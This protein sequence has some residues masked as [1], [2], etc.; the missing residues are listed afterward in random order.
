MSC[1]IIHLSISFPKPSDASFLIG[2]CF[3]S[4][5]S[6]RCLYYSHQAV[7][8]VGIISLVSLSF[9]PV[10]RP[11]LTSHLRLCVPNK[12]LS[13]LTVSQ[14]CCLPT[15]AQ[16]VTSPC[17][18]RS[19]YPCV[20]NRTVTPKRPASCWPPATTPAQQTQPI[21]KQVTD[22][23]ITALRSSHQ[24]NPANQNPSEPISSLLVEYLPLIHPRTSTFTRGWKW[25]TDSS[26]ETH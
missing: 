5:S 26:E 8:L 9:N 15:A 10:S 19:G 2:S 16:E 7:F 3:N 20:E 24:Q 25:R 23:P 13:F 21:A 1:D 22:R 18:R 6:H 17:L 14:Q 11:V 12:Q 4:V